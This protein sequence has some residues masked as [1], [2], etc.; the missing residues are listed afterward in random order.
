MRLTVTSV[1]R[2][3]YQLSQMT[4]FVKYRNWKSQLAT[5]T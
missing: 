4:E 1:Q 5:W 3:T 2:K